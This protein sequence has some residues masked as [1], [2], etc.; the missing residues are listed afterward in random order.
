MESVLYALERKFDI[1]FSYNTSE[2]AKIEIDFEWDSLSLNEVLIKLESATSFQYKRVNTRYVTLYK[3]RDQIISICGYLIDGISKEP[4]PFASVITEDNSIVVSTDSKGYFE[5]ENISTNTSIKISY[6]GLEKKMLLA[7]QFTN[8]TGC[9]TILMSETTEVLNEVLITDYLA[10]GM[11]KRTDG[12][13]QI[14]PLKLGILPGLTEPDIFKSLQLLPGVQNGN[15]SASEL[16]IRGGSPDHNLVLVDGIT[17]YETGHFFGLISA[18][19]PYVIN[20][21]NF[22]KNAPNAKYGQRIGAVLDINSGEEI[23]E[24][25]Y[26][27]GS[28]LLHADA[29]LKTPLFDAKTGFVFSFRRSLTD[30]FN[31]KP[32]DSFSETTL[33]EAHVIDAINQQ[34]K[35]VTGSESIYGNTFFYR[36]FNWKVIQNITENERL[37]LSGLYT[38]NKLDY[39]EDSST[40]SFGS[41]LSIS[42]DG[43]SIKWDKNWNSSWRLVSSFASSSYESSYYGDLKALENGTSESIGDFKSV[44]TV[45]DFEF[46]NH[47][48]KT[49]DQNTS[50]NFGY[51]LSKFSVG[52][53]Y[54]NSNRGTQGNHVLELGVKNSHTHAVFTTYEK[55][56]KKHWNLMFGLRIPYYTSLSHFQLEPRVSL[57][58]QISEDFQ[59]RI[60]AESKSQL[61]RQ[62]DEYRFDGLDLKDKIW[63]LSNDKN[64][65]ILKNIQFSAGGV[66]YKKGW[67]L[68]IDIYTKQFSGVALL[69]SSI[70]TLSSPY[71]YGTSLTHG[72]DFLI[73]K[74]FYNYKTWLSYTLS[75]TE[76][77]FEKLD[78][79][80]LLLGMQ[81]IP[82]SF[83]WSHNYS[84]GTVDL[85]LGLNWHSGIPYTAPLDIVTGPL[86][87]TQLL[88]GESRNTERLPAYKKVDFSVIYNFNLSKNSR[89]KGKIGLSLL[90]VF[91][92]ENILNR[93]HR[94]VTSSTIDNEIM[95][96]IE[97]R[98]RKSLGSTPNFVFRVYF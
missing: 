55:H 26:G 22:Y 54:N 68:D 44:N 37:I 66:Y 9:Q 82:H 90:N 69:S 36:D 10:Q 7:G 88:Y 80:A 64:V 29:F 94:I 53:D 8:E 1:R 93:T 75:S 30:V 38:R 86:N 60:S 5:I 95:Y 16:Y 14:S 13:I 33:Q 79:G 17:M 46:T 62:I 58:K 31:S 39:F 45:D 20:R 70:A 4:V 3:P 27:F 28:N 32:Y 21:V 61:I 67:S 78:N 6:L 15:E 65:P 59:L 73:K 63:V 34:S 76:Y 57:A 12:S 98:E 92:T 52:Y 43:L 74:R 89:L 19:N 11:Q 72:L 85:S 83:V 41:L 71:L 49:I 96:S 18:L 81:D 56:T 91:D 48:I 84:M 47:L 97:V 87:T 42:N 40:N 25:T 24:S 23:F 2:I 51:Q 35:Q 50:W 77:S